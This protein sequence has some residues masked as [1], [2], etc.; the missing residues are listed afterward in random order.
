LAFKTSYQ[1]EWESCL[2][3]YNKVKAT[4]FENPASC[5]K[6]ALAIKS[7]IVEYGRARAIGQLNEMWNALEIRM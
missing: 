1:E 6:S 3:L 4:G 2:S 7:H 5:Y